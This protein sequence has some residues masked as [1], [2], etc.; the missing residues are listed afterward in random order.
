M[1]FRSASL[2]SPIVASE[3]WYAN[4][5]VLDATATESNQEWR[6]LLALHA[7]QKPIEAGRL[8][9]AL[10]R[11]VPMEMRSEVWL[12]FSGARER[13]VQHPH[14]YDQLC[15]RVA[16]YHLARDSSAAEQLPMS[17]SPDSGASSAATK[18][19]AHQ[20][21]EQVEKDLRRTEVGSDGDK[22]SA[23]RRV[24]CAFASFNPDVGYVQG[25]NFIVVALLRIFDEAQSFWMLALIV[26]DWLPD[27]FSHAMVGNHIDC[28]VLAKL[29]AEHLP[30]LAA[31]LAE[32][33]VS[34]Q[35]LTTRWFLCLWSSVLPV[36]ALHRLWDL[37]FVMGPAGSM[38]AALACMTLCEPSVL[39][40]RDIGDALTS[41]KEV[42]RLI[43]D[44][45]DQL[46]DVALYRIAPISREQLFAWR[47]HCRQLV[48]SEARHM[49]ATRRLLKLQ[50]ASGFS[51]LEL[52]LMARLC[53]PYTNV[54]ADAAT[55]LLVR[56][57]SFRNESLERM[58]PQVAELTIL[59]ATT[60]YTILKCAT[61]RSNN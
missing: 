56:S 43:G 37:L 1:A 14:V 29:T 11:G 55:S 10:S 59:Y 13:M 24:L 18:E 54:P 60:K 23:M 39:E 28:R 34:V 30:R 57:V 19:R 8:K 47:L 17:P 51:L 2:S 35:L 36:R 58:K 9:H 40:A 22:L 33:D 45:G 50:R 38:Q 25:M 27:H 15:K 5:D 32:L 21:L 42:L 12:A 4:S 53:G 44:N 52:K 46:L 61:H 26:Q 7:A 20:V 16:A 48:V 3:D 49:Q 41:V 6:E 31:R